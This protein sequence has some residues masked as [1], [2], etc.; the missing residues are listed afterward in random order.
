[1]PNRYFTDEE[2][3]A[4]LDGETDLA[5]LNEISQA[6]EIDGA[7]AKRVDALRIDKGL[8][9]NAFEAVGAAKKHHLA[10]SL[11]RPRKKILWQTVVAASIALLVGFSVGFFTPG[12]SEV[13]WKGYV[14]AYQ[15][16]YTNTTL[17]SV[18]QSDPL[19]QRELARVSAAIGKTISAQQLMVSSEIEYKRG[20]VLGFKGRALVQ[21]AFLSSTGD[22]LALC[23]IKT[24]GEVARSSEL[25]GAGRTDIEH[26]QMEGM[27]SASW[28]R[29]G[30]EFLLIGGQD[31][32]LVANL[33]KRFAEANL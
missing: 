17:A 16:L 21:L 30:Y 15:A 20:Q 23:I 3:V 19:K 24:V 25:G 11:H 4:Y 27:S 7:L 8:I 2:L 18:N 22:P 26:V 28:T 13:D 29:N 14:A 10:Q 9:A 32:T 31:S 5:P 6:I 33:A 1:M 12:R